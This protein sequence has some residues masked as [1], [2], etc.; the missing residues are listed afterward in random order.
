MGIPW[1]WVSQVILPELW[2]AA[3][4][5][6]DASRAGVVSDRKRTQKVQEKVRFDP[7]TNRLVRLETRPPDGRFCAG[8]AS[9]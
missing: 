9:Q 1:R 7:G 3:V 4:D 6:F 8:H 2:D 5:M